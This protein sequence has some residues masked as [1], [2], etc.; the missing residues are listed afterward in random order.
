MCKIC[1]SGPTDTCTLDLYFSHDISTSE[2]SLEG[3]NNRVWRWRHRTRDR[4]DHDRAGR[5]GVARAGRDGV[6][7]DGTGRDGADRAALRSMERPAT[8]QPA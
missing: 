7:R 8:E 5:D 2:S 6:A 4:A 1:E 3:P